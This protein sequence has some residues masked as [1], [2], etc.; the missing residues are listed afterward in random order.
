MHQSECI[1]RT[2]VLE[3]CKL[4]IDDK[5]ESNG[6]YKDESNRSKFQGILLDK[7]F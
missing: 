1:I 4:S 7:L 5:D 2:W 3:K 6:A